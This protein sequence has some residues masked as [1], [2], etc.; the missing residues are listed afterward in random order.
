MRY[1]RLQLRVGQ[2]APAARSP[3]LP[4]TL[5]DVELVL[6]ISQWHV[7]E[8]GRRSVA[9]KGDERFSGGPRVV[10][11]RVDHAGDVA[12]LLEERLRQHH[13]DPQF[14]EPLRDQR[15]G[16]LQGVAVEEGGGLDR[17]SA[18]AVAAGDV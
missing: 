16:G 4:R 14:F 13:L 10:T 2:P 9:Q 5:P 15:A 6:V 18:T 12:R 1:L 17:G 8:F 11:A 3:T 7:S